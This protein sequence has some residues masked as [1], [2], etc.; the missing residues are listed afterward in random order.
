MKKHLIIVAV[1]M[2][3]SACGGSSDDGGGGSG[4]SGGGSGGI[5]DAPTGEIA[6]KMAKVEVLESSLPNGNLCN[7]PSSTVFETNDLIVGYSEHADKN[8]Y[9]RDLRYMAQFSQVALNELY[10]GVGLTR[11]ELNITDEDKWVVCFINSKANNGTG[12]VQ[13]ME[14]SPSQFAENGLILVKHELFHTI[15]AELL[16]RIEGFYFLPYWFQE[17][18]AEYYARDMQID[19]VTQNL[20]K[21]FHDHLVK[22]H[23]HLHSTYRVEY[24][25]EGQQIDNKFDNDQYP[26]FLTALNYLIEEGGLE[27]GDILRLIKGSISDAEYSRTGFDEAVL[28]LEADGGLTIPNYAFFDLSMNSHVFEQLVIDD[29]LGQKEYSAEFIS[30]SPDVFIK[31]VILFDVNDS[32]MEK[33]YLGSVNESQTAYSYIINSIPDSD[34]KVY[35]GTNDDIIYGPIDGTVIN[36]ELGSLDF[37]NVDVCTECDD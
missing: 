2:S 23:G 10:E 37:T 11:E 8:Q 22:D 14:A 5:F 25:S 36:G 32:T 35:A 28:A 29:W 16:G 18:T 27:S 15:Q 7:H 17:A 3:I 33:A 6:A 12:F 34:Y 19:N 13:G 9:D 31:E 1:A 21:S 4:G 30:V 24:W 26:V 20:M